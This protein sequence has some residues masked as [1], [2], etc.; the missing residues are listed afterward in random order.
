MKLLLL[1]LEGALQSWGEDAKWDDRP[2]ASFP[3]KSGVIGLIACCMGLERGD[4]KINRMNAELSFGVRADRPGRRYVDFQTVSSEKMQSADKKNKDRTIIS[5]REYLQDASFLCALSSKNDELSEEIM[6]ALLKPVWAPYLGRKSCVP[7]RP[8]FAG[9]TEEYDSFEEAF[10][11]IPLADTHGFS[12]TTVYAETEDP[13]GFNTRKDVTVNAGERIFARRNVQ[14]LSI[15]K[16][17][18]H[19]PFTTEA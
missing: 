13:A 19:V 10:R 7:S 5:H 9:I 1:R 8:V 12:D 2:S 15:A 4:E 16:G 18:I 3:T 17:D 11:S 6:S 14:I